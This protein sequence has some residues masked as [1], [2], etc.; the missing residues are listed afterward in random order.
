MSEHGASSSVRIP[1]DGRDG[2]G[3]GSE[4]PFGSQLL[5]EHKWLPLKQHQLENKGSRRGSRTIVG[6]QSQQTHQNSSENNLRSSKTILWATGSHHIAQYPRFYRR[7]R[8][9][10]SENG[11]NL[12]GTSTTDDKNVG[13]LPRAAR[14]EA[15][16]A[17]LEYLHSTRSLQFMDAENISRNS[18]H[19]LDNLLKKV[20]NETN[21]GHSIARFLRYHPINEFE[22]FFESMGLRPSEYSPLLP[23]NLMFLNDDEM[24]LENYHVLCN[25]GIARNK[26]GKIYKEATE[27]FRYDYGVLQ[28][29][30]RAFEEMGLKQLTV[31]KVVSSSPY[32]LIGDVNKEFHKVLEKLCSVGIDHGWIEGHLLEGNSYNWSQMLELLCLLS[33]MGCSKEQ[34]G[35]LICQ[36]PELLLEGS[37]NAAF[38]LIGFLLKFGSTSNDISSML[39]QFPQVQVRKFV[40]NLRKCYNFLT[41][42]DMEVQGIGRIVRSY[43]I[44]LGSCS[45]KKV[46]SLLAN[47]NTGKRRLCEIIME[48]PQVLKYWVL[49]SR[50]KR[51]PD[52][53]EELRSRMMRTKF[54][55][56]LGFV[57]NSNEMNKAL[58]IF[59]GRGGELQERF[60]C[61]INAG[62]NQK[63]VSEM[64]KAAPQVLNQSK[65]VINMKI[66]FLVNGLGYPLSSL[67]S[68]PA[69]IS[70][71]I[72][73]VKLRCSMYNWLKDQGTVEPKRALSTILAC[74]DKIFMRQYVKHH[75]KGPEVWQKLKKQIYTD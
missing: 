60:N 20:E 27:V 4:K 8:A 75:P 31:I 10:H 28:S 64:I 38:S 13:R 37:G 3:T 12:D 11:Q 58:K 16:A 24:L 30:L 63:D 68:F 67:V 5:C 49:G 69:Y 14:Q 32:L 62:L 74:S 65:D 61:F 22:P 43:P 17:L 52:S 66:D 73:R 59:R 41:E 6:D 50:V 56:D 1:V 26:I 57:E 72:Q 47:L 36:H 40:Y 39:V 46:N 2:N 54:L 7:K 35:G 71:T 21:V 70:Y 48:N 15:Q 55:L 23:R 51:L 9:V 19:F 33:E 29:K 25:Y 45:L 42:I 34:L 44:L 53:G 18:P